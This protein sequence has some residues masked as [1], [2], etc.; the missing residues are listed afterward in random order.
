MTAL[1]SKINLLDA[2]VFNRIAA[3]EVVESPYSVVKELVENSI[4]AGATEITIKIKG[5]GIDLVAVEDNGFG[6]SKEDLPKAFLPHATSKI[7]SLDDLN[8]IGSLGF[9][10]EA[11][12]SIA[13]VA[14][15]TMVSRQKNDKL[16]H[17]VVYKNGKLTAQNEIGANVGTSVSVKN[18]FENIP[19]RKKFLKKP[20]SETSRITDLVKKLIKANPTIAFNYIVDEAVIYRTDG[21]GADSA[22][23]A[24]Y[25]EKSEEFVAISSVTPVITLKGYIS[26][27]SFSKHNRKEQTLIINNRVVENEELS[28]SVFLAYKDFLLPRKFPAYILYLNIPYDLIDVNVHPNKMLVKF[29]DSKPVKKMI[30]NT[31]HS[32]LAAASRNIFMINDNESIFESNLFEQTEKF[33]PVQTE[34]Q[35]AKPYNDL[36][37]SANIIDSDVEFLREE[38][39]SQ[40]ISRQEV[41]DSFSADIHNL[42]MDE[43]RS[44]PA[45]TDKE[46]S[47]IYRIDTSPPP[48]TIIGK[49]FNTYL[50]IQHNDEVL[51]IDQHAAHE[52]ILYDKY[53]AAIDNKTV[54]IQDLLIPHIFSVHHDESEYLNQNIDTIKPLGF[55]I[56]SFGKNTFRLSAVPSVCER[57]KLEEFIT[58][59]LSDT[60]RK[61]K[62]SDF[63]KEKIAQLACKA[64]IKGGDDLSNSDIESLLSQM[65]AH[66][67]VFLCPHGRP[68][69]VKFS[70]TQIEK[71]FKRIV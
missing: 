8:A 33:V 69:I 51:F 7:K 4:D 62:K 15:V 29:V 19:A 37:Y 30:Y 23:Y 38:N 10:G 27:P 3:G 2:S 46:H 53:I 34:L 18:L 50:I 71:W 16:G 41:M 31:I 40:A 63:L 44:M 24:I 57:I 59:L 35:K 1:N 64:A 13:S 67:G 39:I 52:R 22:I 5:G 49:L 14:E 68:I 54:A 17:C 66:Q 47:Q 42:H 21:K 36:G 56:E 55:H 70:K 45:P 6:I 58:E 61:I 48:A 12:P 28:Y 11:L 25:G 32:A 9:R 43:G 60:Q 20:S 26:L 65:Q